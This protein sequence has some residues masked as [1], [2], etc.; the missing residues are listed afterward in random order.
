MN[1]V[2]RNKAGYWDP[3]AGKAI[4]RIEKAE[5]KKAEKKEELQKNPD[6][7][8]EKEEKAV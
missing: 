6:E 8:T 1:E 7:V 2:F 4:S 3:T 5:K